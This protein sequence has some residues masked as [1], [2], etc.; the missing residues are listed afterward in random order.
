M[1]LTEVSIVVLN[2]IAIVTRIKLLT[3]GVAQARGDTEAVGLEAFQ[4]N[5]ALGL[6]ALEQRMGS[7]QIRRVDCAEVFANRGF[8]RPGIN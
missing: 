1:C 5:L 8:Q 3:D 2:T 6:S 7:A 4:H